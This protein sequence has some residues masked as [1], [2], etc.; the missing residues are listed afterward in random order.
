MHSFMK[1]LPPLLAVSTCYHGICFSISYSVIAYQAMWVR[2]MNLHITV[3]RTL[4][5]THRPRILFVFNSVMN[6]Y[7]LDKQLTFNCCLY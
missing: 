7:E 6:M 3:E 1:E 4:Q 2:V 5:S